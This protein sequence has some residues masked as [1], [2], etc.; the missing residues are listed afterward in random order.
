MGTGALH[1]LTAL[2]AQRTVAGAAVLTCGTNQGAQVILAR[3]L[4]GVVLDCP[5]LANVHICQ[6]FLRGLWNGCGLS[7]GGL[8]RCGHLQ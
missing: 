1:L 5:A 4:L 6:T 7:C 8:D 2:C 3:V